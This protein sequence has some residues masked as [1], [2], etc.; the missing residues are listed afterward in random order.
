MPGDGRAPA[1]QPR[2][3][4]E[5]VRHR[6]IAS[7]VLAAPASWPRIGSRAA[8][9]SSAGSR[10]PTATT[11]IARSVAKIEKKKSGRSGGASSRTARAASGRPAAA[12]AT[13]RASAA[14]GPKRVSSSWTAGA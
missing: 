7:E 5:G 14:S 3:L 6:R 4:G 2:Q 13:A 1:E 11:A 12:R 9:S 10:W 8:Y